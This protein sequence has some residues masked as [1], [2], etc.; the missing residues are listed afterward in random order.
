MASTVQIFVSILGASNVV[1]GVL[2]KYVTL[3]AINYSLKEAVSLKGVTQGVYA[4]E[5]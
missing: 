5:N 1:N 2:L 3:H 4:T